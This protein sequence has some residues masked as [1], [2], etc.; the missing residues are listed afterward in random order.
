MDHVAEAA[1][2]REL[3]RLHLGTLLAG[4]LICVAWMPICTYTS[5]AAYS[6]H[7]FLERVSMF[8]RVFFSVN[9]QE[10]SYLSYI[11]VL[12]IFD[13]VNIFSLFVISQVTLSVV[14]IT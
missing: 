13:V 1:E 9:L 5:V 4:A 7:G 8:Y 2:D 12:L 11:N 6:C 14:F 3:P 10:F